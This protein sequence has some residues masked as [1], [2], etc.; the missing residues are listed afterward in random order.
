MRISN[1]I[2]LLHSIF[3]FESSDKDSE[4]Y[5]LEYTPEMVFKNLTVP[6]SHFQR[7]SSLGVSRN[8]INCCAT[9]LMNRRPIYRKKLA[10]SRP[11]F[12]TFIQITSRL[13]TTPRS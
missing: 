13:S 10:F 7:W 4:S 2:L 1:A 5:E 11:E 6:K 8:M 12:E 9:Q 3:G